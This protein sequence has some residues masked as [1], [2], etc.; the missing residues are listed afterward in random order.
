MR[1]KQDLQE[2]FNKICKKELTEEI[3]NLSSNYHSKVTLGRYDIDNEK[4]ELTFTTNGINWSHDI[5]VSSS[6]AELF[7][8]NWFK[9]K[10]PTRAHVCLARFC[11]ACGL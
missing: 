9:H 1:L 4:F 10:T 7:K 11:K 6:K 5:S 2:Q 8:K 3:L